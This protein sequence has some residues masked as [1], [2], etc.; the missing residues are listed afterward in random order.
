MEGGGQGAESGLAV[1]QAIA[2]SK[3]LHKHRSSWAQCLCCI[4]VETLFAALPLPGRGSSD[5]A[6]TQK[7]RKAHKGFF[8]QNGKGNSKYSKTAKNPK[9]MS[10]NG[11]NG[12]RPFVKKIPL[13]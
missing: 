13:L 3:W 11:K 1:Q 9:K 7:Q 2:W 10:R 12:K 8:S 4:V 6:T 5:N